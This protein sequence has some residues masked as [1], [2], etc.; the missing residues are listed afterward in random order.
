MNLTGLNLCIIDIDI[1]AFQNIYETIIPKNEDEVV[2]LVDIGNSKTCFNILKGTSSLMIRNNKLGI[3]KLRDK[4]ISITNCTIKQA[5][6]II[7]KSKNDFITTNELKKISLEIT[8]IW[9]SE[10][11]SVLNTYALKSNK[12]PIKKIIFSGG[13]VFINEFLQNL[14]LNIPAEISIFN[15]FK[16]GNNYFQ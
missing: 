6:N 3:S 8:Q 16:K 9:C 13:G 10:L 2:M 12:E 5:E 15:P 4:I 14:S 11:Y 7:L 1:F